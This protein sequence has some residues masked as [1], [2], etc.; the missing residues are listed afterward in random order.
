MENIADIYE[1][2]PMQQGML[3]HTLYAPQSGVYFEQLLFTLQGHLNVAAFKQAWIQIISRYPVFRT[4][5]HWD[6]VDKPLQVVHTDV[7]L[8]W[9]EIN[10]IGLT[11]D[12]QEERLN[13]FIENDRQQGFNLNRAPLMRLFLI[14]VEADTFQFLWSHHHM[15]LD[16]WCLSIVFKEVFALYEALSQGQTLHLETPRP[17]RDY[18]VWLQQQDLAKAENFWRQIL[19]GFVFPTPVAVCQASDASSHPQET[20]H[21]QHLWLSETLTDALKSFVRRYHLTLGTLVQGAWALLLSRY[22][23]ESDVVFGVTVSGRPAT[24]Q[25]VE[26][27][28]GLFINTLPARMQISE[29]LSLLSWLQEL[30]IQQVACEQYAYTPLLDIQGWSDVPAGTPLFES[31]VVFENYPLDDSLMKPV[32]EVNI[33]N[34]RSFE[35]TNYPLTLEAMPG[36]QLFLG[37]GYEE[38]R[39]EASTIERMLGHLQVLLEGIVTRPEQRLAELPLLTSSERRQLLVEWNST[40]AEFA[41]DQCIHHLFEAQVKRT[42]EA[43]AVVF[44]EQELT[45][46]ELNNRANQLAHHLQALGVGSEVLVG[47][48]MER[49]LEMIVGV[50]SILK[51]GG[52]YVPLDP[53][54]PQERL[55]F[56][57]EDTQ[58]ALL[59]TQQSLLE[60]LPKSKAK[61]VNLDTD[62]PEIKQ[63]FQDNLVTKIASHNLAYVIYTS[64]S[65]GQPKGVLVTHSNLVNAYFAWETAY[66]LRTQARTHLQ[67]ASFSFDVFGGNL[68]RALCSGGKLVL[69]PAEYLLIA[70]KLYELM[71]HQGVD[72]AE[73]VPAV[74]RNLMEYLYET[75]KNLDFMKLMIVGSDNW[76][77]EEHERLRKLCHEKTL[78][79]NSYGVT[80][81]TVDSCY[82][83]GISNQKMT[84]KLVPIG[85]PFCNMKLYVLDS[86]Q[87]VV[88]IGVTGELYIGGAGVARGYLNRSELTQEKFIPTP[89]S[90]SKSDRLYRTG[91][92]VRYLSDGNIELLGRIDT[93]VKIRGFRIELGEV[94]ATLTQHPQ[95]REAVIVTHINQLGNKNLVAYVVPNQESLS[96]HELR[97]FLR[98]SLPD[99]M[100]PST[101]VTLETLPLTPNGKINRKA[102]PI[103]VFQSG[104]EADYVAPRT[105]EEELV[106]EI[107]ADLLNLEKVGVYDNFFE[108]GGHSLLATQ[109]ISRLYRTFG[110]TLPLRSLFETPEISGITRVLIQHETESGKV[111]AIARLR[112]KLNQMSEEEI[113]TLL[114]KE[115]RL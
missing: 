39:F 54:Y 2:S 65:T 109:L 96:S 113:H 62:W 104:L 38:C 66:S 16:G 14:Q 91:D 32:Q 6:E 8:P 115:A 9:E 15:L 4:S 23:G 112:K 61:I 82:F 92:V 7:D 51:A 74:I 43:A 45:Y 110:I 67:M 34:V 60:I 41:Q 85:R 19:K 89:F 111:A 95:V 18:I 106:A 48:C 79:V 88:P 30:Q 73:F 75:K 11:T 63:H 99:Y 71:Q 90:D 97:Q 84:R 58:V 81:A 86:H 64:G 55:A 33:Q 102:L 24:L 40:E 107:W 87:Q 57:L 20:Y 101:F 36:Q 72:S 56:M 105:P 26:S 5:F 22:S 37:I 47:I 46:Q 69:C 68:V 50:L 80:E 100:L 12:A 44:Q 10:W 52:A 35:R 53:N 114:Q 42:P 59:L 1:L 3:F 49:S 21:E 70:E 83:D 98:R 13:T 27:M 103:P 94:E 93:Q 17:Y 108:L 76:Y 31:V 77:I 25:G 28:V 78:L 29:D